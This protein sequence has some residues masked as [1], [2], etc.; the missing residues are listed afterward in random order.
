MAFIRYILGYAYPM[1][2]KATKEKVTIEWFAVFADGSKMR[3]VQG[4]VHNAWDVKC[5]CGWESKTGGA[6]KSCMIQ[7][8]WNHKYFEHD[9]V[10]DYAS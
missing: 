2:L 10:I 5:S 4:F 3:N 9:Y 6:I 7:E 1:K 8:V